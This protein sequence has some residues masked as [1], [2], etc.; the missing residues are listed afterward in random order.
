MRKEFIFVDSEMLLINK[1]RHLLIL[2]AKLT[3]FHFPLTSTFSALHLHVVQPFDAVSLWLFMLRKH[4]VIV[5]FEISSLVWSSMI[6]SSINDENKFKRMFKRQKIWLSVNT[7][8]FHEVEKFNYSWRQTFTN[9][10]KSICLLD[11]W[12]CRSSQ[13]I[14]SIA[15]YEARRFIRSFCFPI[16]SP[17]RWLSR[18]HFE[19]VLSL[20]HL[21]AILH[22]LY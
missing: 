10:V 20:K 7:N 8:L 1:N 21:L 22:F 12:R 9:D 14:E 5:H 18:F 17:D 16:N 6:S 19:H 2:T 13:D 15:L 4:F 3:E 11:L